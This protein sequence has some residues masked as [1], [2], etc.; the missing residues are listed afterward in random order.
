MA[1]SDALVI[2]AGLAGSSTAWS[3]AQRGINVIVLE[4]HAQPAT[5]ASGNAAGIYMPALESKPSLKESFYLDALK[6]LSGRLAKSAGQII[7]DKCG[8]IHLPRDEKQAQR[9]KGIAKRNDLSDQTVKPMTSSEAEQISGIKNSHSGLYYP[10]AGW[11][12]PQSLCKYYLAHPRITVQHG[13]TV[14]SVHRNKGIWHAFDRNDVPLGSGDIAI[15]SG[16]HLSS[17]LQQAAWLP[18]HSVRGQI[19]QLT[20]N[21]PHLL[22]CVVCHQGYVLPLDNQELIIGAT[23][24]REREDY[25]PSNT[26][27]RQNIQLLEDYL[28]DFAQTLD[29]KLKHRGRVGFRSVVPGRLPLAGLLMPPQKRRYNKT[30]T[31][32]QGLAISAAHASR[33]VLSSGIAG[34]IIAAQLLGEPSPYHSYMNLLTPARFLEYV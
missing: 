19:T 8:V 30:L 6:L 12:S 26:E 5:E 22:R 2:G 11:L 3:L 23:Y 20:L 33:G 10:D 15:L 25:E 7:H 21:R 29:L 14:Q 27:H 13:A 31:A 16:G 28:P 1:H 9:F 32:Y 17:N 4:Q 18:F 34:E 24:N